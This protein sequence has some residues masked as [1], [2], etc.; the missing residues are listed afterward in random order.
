MNVQNRRLQA[1]IA[2]LSLCLLLLSASALTDAQ[3]VLT[4]W[5]GD[6]EV[7]LREYE[8]VARLFEEQNPGVK[9][10]LISQSGTQTQ[11]MEKIVLAIV[12]GAPPDVTWLEGSGVIQFAAQ[13]L[14]ADM[15]DVLADLQ[16]A[17][18]DTQEMTYNGRIWAVPYHTAS[19]GLFKRIDH[20]EEIGLDPSV[21]PASLDELY[22]WTQKLTR[23][24]PS[25]V[26][27]RAGF[28]PWQG[29]WGAPAWIWAFGGELLEVVGTSYRPTATLPENVAAF[30]WIREWGNFYGN[31]L[32]PVTGG[33]GGLQ[34]GTVSMSAESTSVVNR[35]LEAG[36][37]FVVGR[38]PHP[39]GGRNGTWGGGTA[40]GVPVNAPNMEWAL[41]LA[42]FF[43]EVDVQIRRFEE[44]PNSLP[45]NWDALITV[46]RQLPQVWWPLLDQLPEARPRTPLWIEYYVGQ[47]NPAMN[48]VV[49]GQKTPQ[50][51][52]ADVQRVMEARFI[53][54]FGQ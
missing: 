33:F 29:N 28:I 38:V 26:Y 16:F 7:R 47:L 14:L 12:S 6:G 5:V 45:A 25:G 32:N 18:S 10:E 19:R 31:Q 22:S 24:D 36:V 17:P 1:I 40:V 37:P 27:T 23:V 54:V 51:A 35:L 9:V 15:T 21:D 46:G 43:G 48:A 52:L 11:V 42:R 13:G 3:T 39:P 50:Q 20:F 41:K 49:T 34:A 44:Q 2:Y 53:D 4:V 8:V 30:E